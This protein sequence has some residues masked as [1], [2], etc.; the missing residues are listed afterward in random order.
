MGKGRKAFLCGV[1]KSTDQSELNI[2]SSEDSIL[3]KYGKLYIFG[4]I[5]GPSTAEHIKALHRIFLDANIGQVEIYINSV[6]GSVADSICLY[7]TLRIGALRDKR[8]IKTNI[9]GEC[10]SAAVA[11]SQAG[12]IRTMS[13]NSVI[14]IH[15]MRY[16]VQGNESTH[17]D[18]LKSAKMLSKIYMDIICSRSDSGEEIRQL[19]ERK[20]TCLTAKQCKK[21]GLIDLID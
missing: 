20:E 12:L 3:E 13:K 16:D 6:G 14:N 5:T 2:I 8:F 17:S 11:I 10:S 7:E 18:A 4:E 19:S 9:I 15:E 21:L 1:D